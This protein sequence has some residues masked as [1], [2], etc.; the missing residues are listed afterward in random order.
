MQCG[1]GAA[2]G[3]AVTGGR[4]QGTRQRVSCPLP[5]TG[6]LWEPP[7]LTFLKAWRGLPRGHR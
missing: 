4:G 5:T 1:G 3:S 7:S 6:H 2:D